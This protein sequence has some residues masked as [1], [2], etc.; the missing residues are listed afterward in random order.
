M[1]IC[2]KTQDFG[3]ICPSEQN[4]ERVDDGLTDLYELKCNTPKSLFQL[5]AKV[6]ER[7]RDF[8]V[9]FCVQHLLPNCLSVSVSVSLSLS[10]SLCVNQ[11]ATLSHTPSGIFL[12]LNG[13]VGPSV[14]R[15]TSTVLNSHA[16]PMLRNFTSSLAVPAW[17][18]QAL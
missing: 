8:N 15:E 13:N 17:P 18:Q 12:F 3:K 9:I 5:T 7:E 14:I 2:V 16:G 11:V 1:L 10:L 4:R 6:S